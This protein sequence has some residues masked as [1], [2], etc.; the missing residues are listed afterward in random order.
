MVII[1]LMT[2]FLPQKVFQ[3]IFCIVLNKTNTIIIIRKKKRKKDPQ[4]ED[5][6]SPKENDGQN[7]GRMC[8]EFHNLE[9]YIKQGK[10]PSKIYKSTLVNL[11][12]STIFERC[13]RYKEDS[14][15]ERK[16]G[17]GRKQNILMSI[18]NIY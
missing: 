11:S 1:L 8:R 2:I 10:Y 7:K 15:F 9:S 4:N 17:S 14:S 18:L 6:F 13:K 5:N 16:S 3:H 12:R